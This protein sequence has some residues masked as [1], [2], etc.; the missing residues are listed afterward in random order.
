MRVK[1]IPWITDISIYH[2]HKLHT[3]GLYAITGLYIPLS[4]SFNNNLMINGVILVLKYL[5]LLDDLIYINIV[6]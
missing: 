5:Q 3:T 6:I 2:R 4:L 1:Y